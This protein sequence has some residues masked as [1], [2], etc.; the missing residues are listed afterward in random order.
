[1]MGIET[2]AGPAGKLC[3]RLLELAPYPEAGPVT[4]V[5]LSR[6]MAMEAQRAWARITGSRPSP[7]PDMD[8]AIVTGYFAAAFAL[9]RLDNDYGDQDEDATQIRDAMADGGGVGEHLW[10]LLGPHAEEIAALAAELADLA[11]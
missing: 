9:M 4:A 10:E 8:N 1:M 3:A 6:Y 11:P 7:T 2:P 5:G